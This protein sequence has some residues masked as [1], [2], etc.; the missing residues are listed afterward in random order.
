MS[1]LDELNELFPIRNLPEQ[2]KAFRLYAIEKAKNNG[3]E[4]KE[5]ANEGHINVVI[6][7][8]ENAKVLFTAHYDT[9]RRSLFPN[10]LMPKHKVLHFFYGMCTILP[11]LAISA[12]IGYFIMKALGGPQVITARAAGVGAY[13]VIYLL[14]C[15]LSFKGPVNIHNKNDNTSGV[16]AVFDLIHKIGK[17]D[18]VAYILFDDEEKGKKGSKAYASAHAAV[19][20]NLL[21]VNMDCIGNG[22]TFV[23]GV[24]V[25][26][27]DDP[28][29][30]SLQ[31]ALEE[32]GA[33][34]LPRE[35]TAMNS[36]Q[37]SFSKG[38]GIG[39]CLNKKGFYYTPYIHTAKDTV[40]SGE[41]I[42]KLTDAL[43]SFIQS[44]PQ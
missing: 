39:A 14:L 19:K 20:Q 8:P 23:A 27:K 2:K 32:L 5:E 28:V 9:P 21:V 10:L 33:V 4:A 43:T 36:D 24:P 41:T 26:A 1:C 7:D 38:I 15:F 11:I 12:P 6:G 31:T 17:N 30:P 29:Y 16:A 22:T 34:I 44:M 3:F 35:T 18:A 37:K 25:P 42:D 13:L 40:A